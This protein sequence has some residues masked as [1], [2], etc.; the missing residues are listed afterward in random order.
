MKDA[1]KCNPVAVDF[2]VNLESF[3]TASITLL[4]NLNT[5][6]QTLFALQS[7]NSPS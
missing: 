1:A 5:K 2:I 4:L 6:T 3:G 7:A